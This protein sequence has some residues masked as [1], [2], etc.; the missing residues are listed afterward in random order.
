VK[1]N[2]CRVWV[3]SCG[4]GKLGGLN[5]DMDRKDI[6]CECVHWIDLAVDRDR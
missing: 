6:G 3:V 5:T 2:A 4:E 1:R